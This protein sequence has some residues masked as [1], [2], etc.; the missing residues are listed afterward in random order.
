MVVCI[1]QMAQGMRCVITTIRMCEARG[2]R[3]GSC[4][5]RRLMIEADL[6]S[7]DDNKWARIVWL[8]NI[9]KVQMAGSRCG[10]GWL[11]AFSSSLPLLTDI[12]HAHRG[13]ATAASSETARALL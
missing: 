7:T 11:Q 6:E 8:P 2:W 5:Q 12:G 1:K 13:S 3:K 10:T 9:G 4:L